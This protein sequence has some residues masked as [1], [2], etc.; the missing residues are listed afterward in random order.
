MVVRRSHL[1]VRAR[2]GFVALALGTIA[3]GLIVHWRGSPLAPT[4]RD[5]LG[6][7]LWAM[8]IGWWIGALVPNTRPAPRAGV[9][10]AICWTV[11]FSQLYHTPVLDSWRLTTPGR[12]ILGTGFDVRDLGAYAL[13]VLASLLLELMVRQRAMAESTREAAN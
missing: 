9:A 5:L 12:L 4:V 6:D 7:A 8:M 2:L 13:G 3:V 10:L 11:E 1:A